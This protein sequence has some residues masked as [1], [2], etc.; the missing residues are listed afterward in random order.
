MFHV[1][2]MEHVVLYVVSADICVVVLFICVKYQVARDSN[3]LNMASSFL[4]YAVL[5]AK[6]CRMVH[7]L[8]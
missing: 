4:Y 7:M 3:I 5:A 2:P 6:V 8:V 1:I